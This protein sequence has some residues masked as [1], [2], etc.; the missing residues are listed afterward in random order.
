MPY[1]SSSHTDV[2]QTSVV[3]ESKVELK[4]AGAMNGGMGQQFTS[5][6]AFEHIKGEDGILT[7]VELAAKTDGGKRA[8]SLVLH[9]SLT[10]DS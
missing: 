10:T 9:Q 2:A 8:T 4:S 1:M 7:R 5:F 3:V 6:P